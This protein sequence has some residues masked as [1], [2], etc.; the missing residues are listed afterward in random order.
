MLKIKKEY[1]GT[2]VSKQIPG[3]G[4]I[5]LDCTIEQSQETLKHWQ[6]HFNETIEDYGE[7]TGNSSTGEHHKSASKGD[8]TVVESENGQDVRDESNDSKET[9]V[10]SSKGKGGNGKGNSKAKKKS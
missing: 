6:K 8:A 2:K 1:K 10:S 3:L 7:S 9:K 4:N 5:T